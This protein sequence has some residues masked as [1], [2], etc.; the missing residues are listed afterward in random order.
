VAFPTFAQYDEYCR[1]R[2]YPEGLRRFDD[3]VRQLLHY[4]HKVFFV[5]ERTALENHLAA[6]SDMFGG[7][8]PEKESALQKQVRLIG[9]G[10]IALIKYLRGG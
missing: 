3:A 9:E 4:G 6:L 5:P 2:R 7:E 1:E 8:P 10:Q